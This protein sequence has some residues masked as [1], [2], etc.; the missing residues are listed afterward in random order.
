MLPEVVFSGIFQGKNTE[1]FP[2]QF[3]NKIFIFDDVM[4]LISAYM[5]PVYV[6][7]RNRD[8]VTDEENRL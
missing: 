2:F 1:K 3:R 6:F 7:I 8:C 4:F 5:Y